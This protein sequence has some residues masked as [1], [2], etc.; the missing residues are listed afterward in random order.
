M[1]KVIIIGG[2]AAGMFASIFY[3]KNGHDVLVL[4]KNEKLGKKLYIT[5]KGRCNITNACDIEDLFN[6]VVSNKKF[7]YSAFYTYNNT[8]VMNFFENEGLDIKV[9]RGNRVFPQSDKSQ[10]VI[11]TLKSAMIK[12][13]VSIRY[14]AEVKNLIIE[15]EQVKGVVFSNGKKEMAD[16]V[17]V[18]TGGFSY[19]STGSS[20]DGY[21]FAKEAGHKIVPI[22]QALVP[23]NVK[24][25]WI[26]ELQGLSLRNI[27]GTIYAGKKKIYSEFG[28]LLFTHFGVSG[29][30]IISASSFVT[31]YANEE[32]K[33]SIDLKPAL[34]IEQLDDR[35]L[36]DFE[37]NIN[38]S[39]KNS[40]DALLPKKI[41]PIV[42]LKSGIDEDKKVNEITKEERHKLVDTI[43][44][45]EC[46]LNGFRSY[47]EAII[48]KGGVSVKEINPQT[49]ESKLVKNLHFIG[50]VLDLDALTGGFNLQIAWSTAYMA[51]MAELENNA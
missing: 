47:N 9:E 29:P 23:F 39:F 13:G 15:D 36:R 14:N 35:I 17:T 37:S 31:K 25:E 19:Q 49:M 26:K 1:S 6:N 16:I 8:D 46:T 27:E 51:A 4:E 45:F 48:T 40:L 50:E 32:L 12:N 22:S 5:G 41:I 2:G 42:I 28:E 30:I 18:A 11:N 24:E 7:L 43:K 10:D 3:A 38:K 21:K 44:K 20:G 33:L 34:T